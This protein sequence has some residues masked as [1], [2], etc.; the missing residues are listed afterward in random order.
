MRMRVLSFEMGIIG[1]ALEFEKEKALPLFATSIHLESHSRLH[2]FVQHRATALHVSSW[3]LQCTYHKI[4][5]HQDCKHRKGNCMGT[6]PS[7]L[8]TDRVDLSPCRKRGKGTSPQITTHADIIL[9]LKATWTAWC[10]LNILH[11]LLNTLHPVRFHS[12][13]KKNVDK[14]K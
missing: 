7:K 14:S 10:A 8:Q 9:E 3:Y 4:L 5:I 6:L 2:L 12:H 1:D 11:I 13:R